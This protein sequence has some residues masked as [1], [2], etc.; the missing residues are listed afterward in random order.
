[1]FGYISFVL[2]Q[3]AQHLPKS[4]VVQTDAAVLDIMARVSIT[5]INQVVASKRQIWIR[6]SKQYKV[7]WPLNRLIW[8][9]IP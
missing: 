6:K 4:T 7:L 1:M 5:A 2:L 9:G 8:L 3:L